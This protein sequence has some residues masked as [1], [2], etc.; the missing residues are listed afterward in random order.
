MLLEKA[1]AKVHGGYLSISSGLLDEAMHDLTGAPTS[2]Y[3]L[4]SSSESIAEEHWRQLLTAYNSDFLMAC[5][6][7]SMGDLKPNQTQT[8]TG[9]V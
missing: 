7:R 4:D 1:W 5:G 2:Y 8:D 9:L 3:F 6:T